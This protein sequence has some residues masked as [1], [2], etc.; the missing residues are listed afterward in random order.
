MRIGPFSLEAPLAAGGMGEVWRGT[1]VR[2]GVPVAVKVLTSDATRDPR[3]VHAFRKE[4]RAMAGLCHDGV[5]LVYDFGEIPD[6]LEGI[7]GGRLIAGSPYLVL[8]LVGGRSLAGV[9]APDWPWLRDV[10]LQLLAALA[11]AHAHGVVHRDLKPSNVLTTEAG[12]LVLLDFGLAHAMNRSASI[13]TQ[14]LSS[15]GTPEYMAPEQA[16]GS[17][18]DFGPWTDLYGLGCLTYALL[19]GRP[20]FT[21]RT[22][23]GTVE[24]HLSAQFPP[25]EAQC[26]VPDGVEA[27]IRR[28]MAK[29]PL[30]R[31]Q[32]AA[33]AAWALKR[34][35]PG[36]ARVATAT[37]V[38]AVHAAARDTVFDPPVPSAVDYRRQPAVEG[39]GRGP[40]WLRTPPEVWAG[41]PQ[42]EAPRRLGLEGFALF[43]LRPHPLVGREDARAQLWS[44]LVRAEESASAQV[45]LLRGPQGVGKS[46]LARWTSQMAH[47]TGAAT[48]LAAQ[49][50]PDDGPTGGLAGMMARHLRCVG[51]GRLEIRDRLERLL[52]AAG[53]TQASDW[54]ALTELLAP[55]AAEAR[56]SRLSGASE[57]HMLVLRHLG[58]LGRERPVVVWL[59]DVQWGLDALGF[60]QLVLERAERG[61][62][63]APVLLVLTALDEAL[64]ERPAE[65]S[66]IEAL[67]GHAR[68]RTVTLDPFDGETQLALVRDLLPFETLLARRIAARTG[69]NPLFAVH[70]V[71]DLLA[72]GLLER[73]G[74][75]VRLTVEGAELGLPS[76]L[77]EVWRGRL[78]AFLERRPPADGAALEIAATLGLVVDEAEWEAACV[79][80][81][82]SF[83][84]ALPAD[85]S[86]AGWAV[87]LEHSGWSFV[88]PALRK[89]VVRRAHDGG[90]LEA[91][92][93]A[94]ALLLADA[95]A[96][97][98]V[99][100]RGHHEA[101]AGDWSAAVNTFASSVRDHLLAGELALAEAGYERW[102]EAVAQTG[103]ADVDLRVAEG[104]V[105]ESAVAQFRGD[106]DRAAEAAERAVM[107]GRRGGHSAV[108]AEGLLRWGRVGAERGRLREAME[109]LEEAEALTSSG[110]DL[111]LAGEC[112]VRLGFTHMLLGHLDQADACEERATEARAKMACARGCETG[113]CSCAGPK[114]LELLPAAV[115]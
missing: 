44:A 58:R 37:A 25:V 109:R 31:F 20:P 23:F 4:A 18:R 8:E 86:R 35:D 87:P 101:A 107:A 2:Q 54:E 14:D 72:R 73:G 71:G 113:S 22:H 104:A 70:L 5:A 3:Y 19:C 111:R 97:G 47:A 17:W 66:M 98:Q 88:H 65:A 93:R 39:A 96:P 91:H 16:H 67:Q 85:L 52:R 55:A 114:L 46:Q 21:A 33:D 24:R 10:L 80:A 90:R 51:L 89:S 62:A 30:E 42:P 69:G 36:A 32:R 77:P 45:V 78:A 11:H 110:D 95:T 41:P 68:L 29:A 15:A 13:D 59:D 103:E 100:R 53:E 74:Q 76:D 81:K 34:L 92:H 43:G 112:H 60:V 28:L 106:L 115:S 56:A 27:W 9:Q 12:R 48:T 79:L 82:A 84:E 99:A 105:M 50:G 1:H 75:G 57:R 38:P 61:E 64:L 7:S 6:G 49:H 102:L 94:C 26:D 40:A 63:T 108:L 83:S